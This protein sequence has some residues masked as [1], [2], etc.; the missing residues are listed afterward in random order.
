MWGM[1]AEGTA[2]SRIKTNMRSIRDAGQIL[3]LTVT[4]VVSVALPARATPQTLSVATIISNGSNTTLATAQLIA[5]SSPSTI[6]A[7]QADFAAFGQLNSDTVHQVSPN[8]SLGTAQPVSPQFFPYGAPSVGVSTVLSVEGTIAPSST[9][10]YYKFN[11]TAG[12]AINLAAY[13]GVTTRSVE[14]QLFDNNGNL[15]EAANGN[16]SPGQSLVSYTA[17][18]TQAGTWT[19]GVTTTDG[20]PAPLSYNLQF[21]VPGGGTSLFTTNVLGSGAASPSDGN[22]G[23][24]SFNTNAGDQLT[25]AVS[26]LPSASQAVELSV[27]DPNGSLFAFANGNQAN[28]LSSIVNFVTPSG[29]G[30]NWIAEVAPGNGI[31][32]FPYD[33]TIQGASGLGPVNPRPSVSVNEPQ[34][35]ALLVIGLI[36]IAV[37]RCDRKSAAGQR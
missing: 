27:Y 12:Q 15:V 18:Q 36:A 19:V 20:N 16:G 9:A 8:F 1:S 25:L 11:V 31:S 10:E 26:S 17:N 2:M 6:A 4:G 3:A 22:L 5:P 37:I 21:P 35:G 33:L 30:G 7:A 14:V 32:P 24:Y 28:G 29:N 13:A 23:Y 34:S